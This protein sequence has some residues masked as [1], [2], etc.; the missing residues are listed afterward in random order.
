MFFMMVAVLAV[1]GTIWWSIFQND[2]DN[3]YMPQSHN[4][5]P[6]LNADNERRM[7]E[8]PWWVKVMFHRELKR[9]ERGTHND[10]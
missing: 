10:K 1:G 8:M 7:E 5:S 2:I 6:N 3:Q 4:S 9:R